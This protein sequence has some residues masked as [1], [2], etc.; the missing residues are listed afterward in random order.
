MALFRV[1]DKGIFDEKIASAILG[2]VKERYKIIMNRIR[3]ELSLARIGAAAH[4][5]LQV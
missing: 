1:D 5:I 3:Y 4:S 2:L